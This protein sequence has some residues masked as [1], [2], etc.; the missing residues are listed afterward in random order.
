MTTQV[1]VMSG[2]IGDIFWDLPSW[3]AYTA[4]YDV[5]GNVYV[6][7]PSDTAKE[8]A[9]MARLTR[10]ATVISEEVMPVFGYSWFKVEAGDFVE[11]DGALR[12]TESDAYLTVS[13][14]E[15]ESEEATDLVTTILV[16]PS[17]GGTSALPPA[18]P[19]TGS[20]GSSTGTFDWTSL[21]SWMLPM[22]M[23][24]VLMVTVLKPKQEKRVLP[25]GSKV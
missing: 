15:R 22:V 23:F 13:L 12:F 17:T 2:K 5:G 10:E 25:E 4:G 19:G 6:A 8:Y 3:I 21:M 1:T 11:L 7:N 24:G 9:L 20:T 14:I 18:W 16:A